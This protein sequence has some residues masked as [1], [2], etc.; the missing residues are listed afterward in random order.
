[1]HRQFHR[2]RRRTDTAALVGN[3]LEG[4]KRDRAKG[5]LRNDKNVENMDKIDR[6]YWEQ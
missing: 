6:S 5:V 2:L 1:M 4:T 3:Q